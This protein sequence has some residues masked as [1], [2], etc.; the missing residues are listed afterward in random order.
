MKP[1]YII[2]VMLT[3]LS[4]FCLFAQSGV[5]IGKV[6]NAINNEPLAYVS[7]AIQGTTFAA[8]T[9][10]KGLYEIKNLLPGT[11]NVSAT[12]VGFLPQTKYEILVTNVHPANVDF[13][14]VENVKSLKAVEVKT[15]AFVKNDDSP[16]SLRNIGVAEISRSPGGN[17]DISKVIQSL[18]GVAPTTFRND[19]I[20]RGGAPNEN[21]FYLD[22]IEIPNINHFATQGSSGG[23]VGMIN[24]DFIREVNFYSSAFPANRNNA[25]SSVM[26]FNLKNGRTDKIGGKMTVGA[27]DL[28]LMLEGPANKNATFMASARRSYLQFLFKAIGLPFLPTYDDF[29]VK[30]NWAINKKNDLTFIGLGAI[31][32]STLNTKLQ[33]TGTDA[34][35][36]ILGY[37][38]TYSQWNY[39]NGAKYV[40]FGA[41][42]YTTFVLSRNML[43]NE[44][45]KYKDNVE[46][47]NNRI[48]DYKSQEIE[49]K[50]RIEKTQRMNDIKLNYGI[51]YEYAEYNNNSFTRISTPMGVDTIN[52][53]SK[54]MMNKWGLFAQISKD[55]LGNRLGVSF[56]LRTDANDY[57]Q[58][59]KN[60]LKQLS[61]R[62][63]FSFNLTPQWTLNA[64]TGLYYQLPAY[65]VLGYRNASGELVNK[66]NGVKYIKS[67]H[68]VAGTEY[69]SKKNLKINAEGFMKFFSQYPFILRDSISLANLGSDYGVI[70]NDAVV[71]TSVGRSYGFELLF[72]QKLFKG[73]YGIMTYTFVR[74]EFKDKHDKWVPS[75]WDNRQFLSMTAGK[76]FKKNWEVGIKWRF[77]LGS[78]YT[79]YNIPLSS[80]IASWNVSHTGVPDYNLL[81]TK[82]LPAFHQLDMRV[83]KKYFWKKLDLN[84]YVDIQNVYNSKAV[85]TPILDVVR[86]SNG[87][88][89][90]DPY[91]PTKYQTRLLDNK[92]GT[93]LP[94]IGV[95][96]GF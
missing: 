20:I 79:P 62:I 31:D 45:K 12:S 43:N 14:M 39:M 95:V 94:S 38:P 74:S 64:N 1:K 2:L 85:G 59:M 50:L 73:F 46:T 40:H 21:R 22:G 76:T 16:I 80:E 81:N 26:D 30:Y 61:L 23:A 92:S 3:V 78:P 53:N 56:G 18:P 88:A 29:M 70:G 36:Y 87:N 63:S 17:R 47:A 28:G 27:S 82:R 57:D 32:N 65:T 71:S 60:L 35:K 44:S 51:N 10:D 58:E 7:V 86:D 54:L 55:F 84:F 41:K 48:L 72:Q 8:I 5:I 33:T 6:L 4:R 67:Y 93:I 75:S 49:N 69:I 37:L 19:I 25:L 83:D 90:V 24:V 15:T 89:L 13:A 68:I 42:G 96:V 91:D 34:Q 9:D 52:V 11:Y 66:N 77:S